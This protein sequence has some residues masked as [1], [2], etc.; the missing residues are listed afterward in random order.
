MNTRFVSE[1]SE[2]CLAIICVHMNKSS[3]MFYFHG[4]RTAVISFAMGNKVVLII[5]SS[6]HWGNTK[7]ERP[8]WQRRVK[9][10]L[11]RARDSK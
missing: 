4:A 6:L 10:G 5:I 9:L 1:E 3:Q 2:N 8:Y 7:A 11:S